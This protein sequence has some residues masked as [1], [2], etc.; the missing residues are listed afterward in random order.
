MIVFSVVLRNIVFVVVLVF[1][2]TKTKQGHCFRNYENYKT[3][4]FTA[5]FDRTEDNLTD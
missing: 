4:K 2:I 5:K 3:P 1:I